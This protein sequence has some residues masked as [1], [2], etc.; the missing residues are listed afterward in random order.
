[1]IL[2]PLVENAIKHGVAPSTVGGEVRVV[3]ARED[4]DG[5][6]CLQ[7]VVRNTG[8]P[9]AADYD[10]GG[11]HVGLDNVVRRLAG[12]YGSAARLTLSVDDSGATVAE[13]R[14]PLS[15]ATTLPKETHAEIVASRAGRR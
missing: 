9:L 11:D 2:Q 13:L 4:A 6:A 3:A 5:Q 1:M 10:R 7:I 12:H 8:K 15:A 14:L